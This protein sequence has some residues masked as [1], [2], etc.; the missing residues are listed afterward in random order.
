MGNPIKFDSAYIAACYQSQ[1]GIPSLHLHNNMKILYF[2]VCAVLYQCTTAINLCSTCSNFWPSDCPSV[3]AVG[4]NH[5]VCDIHFSQFYN[6]SLQEQL[7]LTPTCIEPLVDCYQGNCT[8][9]MTAFLKDV[10]CSRNNEGSLCWNLFAEEVIN[11][12]IVCNSCPQ[13]G[14]VCTTTCKMMVLRIINKLGCCA[15]LFLNNT[16][17]PS[18]LVPT[19]VLNDCSVT[20]GEK[21]T[22]PGESTMSTTPSPSPPSSSSPSPLTSLTLPSP[23]TTRIQSST[24]TPTGS[25]SIFKANIVVL[26]TILVVLLASLG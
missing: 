10:L 14:S 22:G 17:L 18:Q 23:S 24:Q 8:E 13:F 16:I 5:Q 9:Q 15:P 26:M 21:C 4:I 11:G 1:G 6:D 7:C 20:I 2:I 3:Q 12:S 19:A 25:G